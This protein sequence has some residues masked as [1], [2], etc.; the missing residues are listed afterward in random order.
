MDKFVTIAARPEPD[1]GNKA[2]RRKYDENYINLGFT[3]TGSTD[4]PRPQCVI[5]KE[6]LANDS[7]RPAKLRRHLTTKHRE[8]AEK[9]PSS[10]KLQ[11]LQG[12]KGV[13]RDFSATNSKATEASYRGALLI[14][15]A[16]K[17]HGI[18]EHSWSCPERLC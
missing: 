12:E 5:C 13:I 8:F 2:K 14:A 4:I 9:P 7:L 16:G 10:F 17:P 15:K 11:G 18:G 6:V 3:W 1:M